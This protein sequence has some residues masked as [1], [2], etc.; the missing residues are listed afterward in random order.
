MNIISWSIRG[1]GGGSKIGVIKKL[2]VEKRVF[3]WGRADLV[4]IKFSSIKENMIRRMWGD[5]EFKWATIDVVDVSRGLMR[6]WGEISRDWKQLKKGTC[7]YMLKASNRSL[8]VVLRLFWFMN[9]VLWL[10]KELS[11]V[12][13]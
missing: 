7:D 12:N 2:V 9:H 6:I 1:L 8:D 11:S 4:E 13:C 5:N 3:F 10:K